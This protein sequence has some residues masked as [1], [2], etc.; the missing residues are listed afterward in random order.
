MKRTIL[1][2][3][4]FLS[5]INLYSQGYSFSSIPE[6]LKSRAC[7]VV[8]T[9]QCL[10]TITKPGHA[11][12]KIKKAITLLNDNS[13]A[14][15]QLTVYYDNDSRVN[16]LRARIYDEKGDM[17]KA[18]IPS[19]IND[20]SAISGGTFYSDLRMKYLRFP[21]YKYP[22]TIEYEYEVEYS[23]LINYDS[24]AFQ[25]SP[26]VSVERSGVQYKVPREMKLRYFGENLKNPV[27]SVITGDKIIYTWQ[28]E[29]IPTM[30]VPSS[31]ARSFSGVPALYTAPLDFEYGG[32]KGSLGSWKSFGEWMYN[33]NKGLDVLPESERL[34]V[35]EIVSKAKDNREK[36]R[37]IYEYMQS[38]TRYVSIQVGIG[39]LRPA[40]ASDVSRSGFGDCKALV[41]YTMALL[42]LAGINSIYTLV[43]AGQDVRDIYKDF[44]SDQFNHIILCVPMERDSV[45][46][47]CTSPDLPFNYLGNFTDD[48]H[49]L[50]VTPEGG[51]L[52]RT[53]A[54]SKETN[55][56][57]ST[58]LVYINILGTLSGNL[59]N[60]YS[61]YFFDK[62]TMLYGKESEEDMKRILYSGLP[63]TDFSISK[64][65]YNEKKTENPSALFSY[66][67]T[68]K[69]FGTRNGQ[70]IYFNPAVSKGQYIQ[71]FPTK[72]E[73]TE[74]IIYSDSIIYSL[75][76]GY[77]V[78]YLPAAVDIKNEF[79]KFRYNLEVVKE[80][81]VY[82]RY[83][84]ID[85]GFISLEKFNDFRNFINLIAKT[86][87]ERI[88]LLKAS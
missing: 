86:D 61:G 80:R 42:K 73:V 39:G 65:T 4:V 88:I 78:E 18:M 79:G 20:L 8:R 75:P 19:D 37:L 15:R 5:V 36:V 64:V 84:E 82:K 74:S 27:D 22:Y 21:L 10:Y 69:D 30:Y 45:W 29:N 48:R 62:S 3:A 63:F 2:L 72:L 47:D 26:D 81:I 7:A 17:I 54:F 77:K 87:R 44:V 38:R 53:P 25:D 56:L 49:V 68:V 85:K 6:N 24:R 9:D 57:N 1:S 71:N 41:N 34:K 52:V 83:F 14:Y 67:L 60:S 13:K 43:E 40:P 23:G 59:S 51:K 32:F 50:L 11:V 46:L 76:L 70:R 58:G 35:L 33:L 55:I 28:E 31:Y 16:Y 66:E 12:E